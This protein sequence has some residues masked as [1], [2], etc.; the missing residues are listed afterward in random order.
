L[1]EVRFPNFIHRRLRIVKPPPDNWQPCDLAVIRGCAEPWKTACITVNYECDNCEF[2]ALNYF[3]LGEVPP[4]EFAGH[5]IPCNRCG[6]MLEVPSIE[7]FRGPIEEVVWTLEHTFGMD[8]SVE[9]WN[10]RIWSRDE[11]A[12]SVWV[13]FAN[14]VSARRNEIREYVIARET[15]K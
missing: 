1:P 7:D 11:T 10:L 4:E 15:A 9:G 8:L 14:E 5:D 3:I 13:A 2:S 6:A 12:K